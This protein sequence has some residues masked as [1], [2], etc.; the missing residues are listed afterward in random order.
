M[1]KQFESKLLHHAEHKISQKVRSYI[2]RFKKEK[3]KTAS[4]L[5]LSSKQLSLSSYSKKYTYALTKCGP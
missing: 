5:F 4:L 2:T 1:S 3:K